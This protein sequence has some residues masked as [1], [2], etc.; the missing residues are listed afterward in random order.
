MEMGIPQINPQ[1]H[2][3]PGT[4]TSRIG[5]AFNGWQ[6]EGNAQTVP[7]S[8]PMTSTNAAAAPVA[9]AQPN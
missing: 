6:A 2:R 3:G 8:R 1:V 7:H 5:N 4:R 9:F